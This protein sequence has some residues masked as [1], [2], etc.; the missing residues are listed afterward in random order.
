[1]QVYR[2]QSK[3]F[4]IASSLTQAKSTLLDTG[5]LK[6]KDAEYYNGLLTQ[7]DP[8]SIWTIFDHLGAPMKTMTIER[9]TVD[10]AERMAIATGSE[11]KPWYGAAML[12]MRPQC[13]TEISEKFVNNGDGSYTPRQVPLPDACELKLRD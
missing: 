7:I 6:G 4:I 8:M 10:T 2:L 9:W 5:V 13:E 12:D 3:M 11:T 1:M